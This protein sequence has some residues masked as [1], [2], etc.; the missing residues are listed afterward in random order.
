MVAPADSPAHRAL[1]GGGEL[2]RLIRSHDWSATSL[3]PIS[4]WPQSLMTSLSVVLNAQM[5]MWLG[6]GP[7][8]IFFYNDA[9]IDVLSQA[10]HPWALGRPAAEVWREIW[11]VCGP[12]AAQVFRDGAAPY[13]EDVRLF[14]DRGDFLEEVYYSFSYS[15]VRDDSGAVAGLF[16]PNTE[17]T[18]KLLGARRLGTLSELATRALL[19][20]T[21]AST[22]A[23]VAD[24]L[25]KNPDD[26]PFAALY[27]IGPGGAPELAQAIQISPA[28]ARDPRWPIAGVLATGA[29]AAIDVQADD[30]LPRG[31][32][33][34]P[35]RRALVLPIVSSNE[36]QPWGVLVAGVNPTRRLDGEY[37]AFFDLVAAQLAAALQ[38]ATSAEHEKRRADTLAEL[39][40]AKTTFFSNISHEFRTPLTLM[41]GPIE[42]ALGQGA[43]LGGE[44]L[45]SVYRN[46]LRQ[47][48]LVN[49]LLD[50]SRLEAGQMTALKEPADL[51]Q[52]TQD[53]ASGFRSAIERAGLRFEVAIE[54]LVAPVAVDRDMWEKIVLNLLSNA[55][56]FTRAGTIR[57]SLRAEGGA[58]T[59]TVADTGTGIPADQMP[60]LFA[61][62]QRID[63]PQARTQ[64]GSGIGL[65]LV[66]ELTRLHGGEVTARSELGQ[67]T[68]FTVAIPFETHAPRL[69]AEAPRRR[70]TW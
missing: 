28:Q 58:A 60:R 61:R 26:I 24:T 48:K 25:R 13:V 65:A 10:K 30:A 9:Y 43:T 17:V 3:G 35:V 49:A 68:A 27:L 67:G 39:D 32:A 4:G 15:P 34:Q 19:E 45:Q 11:H 63:N 12:L 70:T 41:I 42:D 44:A 54:P 57:V 55:L 23:S 31:L 18:A 64:E 66:H 69:P 6:W 46:A 2:G 33:D 59:L 40:R 38:S 1:A 22:C 47:L 37:R 56:K 50:F 14:M 8:I 51:A 53:V 62:F 36:A 20:K 21:T 7:D 5:P 52:L 29:A 16:C